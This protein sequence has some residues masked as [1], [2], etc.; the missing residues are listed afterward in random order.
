MGDI[1][2]FLLIAALHGLAVLAIGARAL[3]LAAI[4][5]SGEHDNFSG[6]DLQSSPVLQRYMC[7][8]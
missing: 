2:R 5:A 3:L 1:N 7:A 6:E 4:D 8:W